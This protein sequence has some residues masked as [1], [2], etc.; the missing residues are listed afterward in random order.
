MMDLRQATNAS[1]RIS[2]GEQVHIQ[3]I[4]NKNT[5]ENIT[6]NNFET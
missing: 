6:S 3:D 1:V 5:G 2:D 4:W